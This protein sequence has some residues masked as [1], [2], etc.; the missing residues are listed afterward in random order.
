MILTDLFSNSEDLRIVNEFLCFSLFSLFFFVFFVFLCFSLC[1]LFL[2]FSL[3]SVFFFVFFVVFIVDVIVATSLYRSNRIPVLSCNS[4]NLIPLNISKQLRPQ[5][6]S[7]LISF[8]FLL[9]R[10]QR[11]RTENFS[12]RCVSTTEW[13]G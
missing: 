1:F 6:Q 9:C 13:R 3:F 2:C 8:I 11:S 4:M 5:P 10:K 12:S 7:V